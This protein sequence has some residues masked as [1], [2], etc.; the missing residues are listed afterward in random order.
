MCCRVELFDH[1]FP[2]QWFKLIMNNLDPS[3]LFEYVCVGLMLLD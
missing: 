1:R 2:G 3:E